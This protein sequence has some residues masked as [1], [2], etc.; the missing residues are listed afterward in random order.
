MK[1]DRERRTNETDR[2]E[3]VTTPAAKRAWTKPDFTEVVACAEIG[4]YAYRAG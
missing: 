1:S 3:T 4:A 2:R